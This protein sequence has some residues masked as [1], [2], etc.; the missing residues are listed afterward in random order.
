MRFR[1]IRHRGLRCLIEGDN[2]RW[3]PPDLVERIRD[4]VAVLI[5]AENIDEFIADARAGWRVHGLTGDRRGTWSVSV[6]GNWRMT[7]EEED[8]F[9]V[10]LDLEDYH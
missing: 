7:F 8:G 5:L 3:L 6:S 10:R 2:E 4:I 1:T 9:V